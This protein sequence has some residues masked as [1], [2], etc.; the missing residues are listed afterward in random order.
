MWSSKRVVVIVLA[1]LGFALTAWACP[2]GQYMACVG[3]TIHSPVLNINPVCS[4][5]PNSGTA[6]NSLAKAANPLP[7]TL[8]LFGAVTQGNINQAYSSLGSLVVN[9]ACVTCGAALSVYA[10][11]QDQDVI[12][13]LIGRGWLA[14]A[15]GQPMLFIVNAAGTQSTAVPLSPPAAPPIATPLSPRAT[16]TFIVTGANCAVVHA[17]GAATIK[18]QVTAGWVDPPTLV[19]IDTHVAATFPDIDLRDGDVIEVTSNDSCQVVPAGDTH[20]KT[21]K[22]AYK[23]PTVV[24]GATTA[25]KYF[26]TGTVL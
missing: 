23:Y 15:S 19:A 16:M 20:V 17:S 21:V 12:E 11:T 24:P 4:C 25:M 6:A 18:S 1:V 3:P 10:S 8:Q 26:L 14:Y 9:S 5:L 2:D 13:Q 22:I 7:N